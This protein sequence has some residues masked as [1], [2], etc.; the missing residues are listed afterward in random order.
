MM[1]DILFVPVCQSGT[2]IIIVEIMLMQNIAAI[3]LQVDLNLA[4]NS[5]MLKSPSSQS[6]KGVA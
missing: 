2:S 5:W 6:E 3:S 1:T 4:R